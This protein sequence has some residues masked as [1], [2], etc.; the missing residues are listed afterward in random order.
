MFLSGKAGIYGMEYLTTDLS[1]QKYERFLEYEIL[2]REY[3]NQTLN[4]I[5]TLKEAYD[6][7]ILS[8]SFGASQVIN[9]SG[10]R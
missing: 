8:N 10:S 4:F 1:P 6:K 9:S 3:I 2:R 5:P 7:Y